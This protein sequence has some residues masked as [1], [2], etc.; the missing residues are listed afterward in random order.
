MIKEDQK[1]SALLYLMIKTVQKKLSDKWIRLNSMIEWF[2]SDLITK[3]NENS[4]I[5]DYEVML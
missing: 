4:N 5:N 3:D 1:D 2:L